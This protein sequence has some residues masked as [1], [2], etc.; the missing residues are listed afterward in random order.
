MI[1]LGRL[2]ENSEKKR[3]KIKLIFFFSYKAKTTEVLTSLG[4]EGDRYQ[5]CNLCQMAQST[6]G[7]VHDCTL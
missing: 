5:A 6:F 4:E 2:I 3:N 7:Q 1:T